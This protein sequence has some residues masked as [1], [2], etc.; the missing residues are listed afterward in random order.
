VPNPS[1]VSPFILSLFGN[2]YSPS[3]RGN[4][5]FRRRSDA[6]PDLAVYFDEAASGWTV[7]S[8]FYH[9]YHS[10]PHLAKIFRLFGLSYD[11]LDD[12]CLVLPQRFGSARIPVSCV[13]EGGTPEAP[14]FK[15]GSIPTF[16]VKRL[17]WAVSRAL[18]PPRGGSFSFDID[19]MSQDDSRI[20][21]P[22]LYT[23]VSLCGN[24]RCV[25]PK[26]L[27]LEP[28]LGNPRNLY[29]SSDYVPGGGSAL[30]DPVLPL[31]GMPWT[32]VVEHVRRAG[33]DPSQLRGRVT[34]LLALL[35]PRVG[36]LATS[37]DRALMTDYPQSV[38]PWRRKWNISREMF[39]PILGGKTLYQYVTTTRVR[40]EGTRVFLPRA[41]WWLIFLDLPKYD[42]NNPEF[43]REVFLGGRS[44]RSFSY[45]P[46]GLDDRG[47]PRDRENDQSVDLN[48]MSYSMYNWSL[49]IP[50]TR[51]GYTTEEGLKLFHGEPSL[52]SPFRYPKWA[53]ERGVPIFNQHLL[54][55]GD[56]VV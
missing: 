5:Y 41:L 34:A 55:F 45:E 38:E 37:E 23:C 31:F 42:K 12:G 48:P 39:P 52:I 11:P 51:N 49:R 54:A 8:Q 25:N 24:P 20:V 17:V 3:G 1:D 21:F 18:H 19:C 7:P 40:V 26:H 46:G 6:P 2:A 28:N 22:R 4:V 10:D 50:G 56:E 53:S 44:T 29:F 32:E 15:K 47:M 30:N 27:S 43:R 9:N 14:T 35:E 36:S 13:K 33:P 16:S